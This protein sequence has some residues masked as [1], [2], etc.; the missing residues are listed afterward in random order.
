MDWEPS[1][2]DIAW[3]KNIMANLKVG[4]Q[5][6]APMGFSCIKVDEQTLRLHSITAHVSQ[7]PSIMETLERTKKVGEKLGITVLVEGQADFAIIDAVG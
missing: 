1:E 2:E 4:G 5:W 7:M 6:I 3:L